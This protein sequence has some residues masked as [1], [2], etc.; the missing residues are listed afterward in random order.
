[1]YSEYVPL[2]LLRTPYAAVVVLS[3]KPSQA[4]WLACSLGKTANRLLLSPSLFAPDH[5]V[6]DS[7]Y[8]KNNL[9]DSFS[10][11]M[12]CLFGIDFISPP[13]SGRMRGG[14]A[15][16]NTTVSVY[17]ATHDRPLIP[18]SLTTDC[19]N[20]GPPDLFLS[21]NISCIY[22]LFYAPAACRLTPQSYNFLREVRRVTHE[23][24]KFVS[25][26]LTQAVMG[27]SEVVRRR[28]VDLPSFGPLCH[29]LTRLV[30]SDHQ[31]VVA[32]AA[33]SIKLLVLDDT[34][35]PEA[36]RAGIPS[37]LAAALI[38]RQGDTA[39]LREVLG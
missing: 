36:T 22:L 15:V 7:I 32:Y 25:L 5:T 24:T 27:I 31:P 10:L 8:L 20:S 11:R 18:P 2:W 19:N 29:I 9:Q 30:A 13:A 1:M 37:V 39:C 26:L 17:S 4:P 28:S 21:R 34:L 35:R 6:G 16:A 38:R 3:Y 23:S 33:R 12:K 14:M